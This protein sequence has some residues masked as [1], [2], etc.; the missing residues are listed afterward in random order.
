MKHLPSG[1]YPALLVQYFSDRLQELPLTIFLLKDDNIGQFLEMAPFLQIIPKI[2]TLRKQPSFIILSLQAILEFYEKRGKQ[3]VLPLVLPKGFDPTR[4][5]DLEWVLE[6]IRFHVTEESKELLHLLVSFLPVKKFLQKGL[7]ST[8]NLISE[9]LGDLSSKIIITESEELKK[10]FSEGIK[11]I[12]ASEEILKIVSDLFPSMLGFGSISLIL[13]SYAQSYDTLVNFII[14]PV[15]AEKFDNLSTGD[16]IRKLS[17]EYPEIVPCLKVLDPVLRNSIAHRNYYFDEITNEFIYY[18]KSINIGQEPQFYRA[19]LDDIRSRAIFAKLYSMEF[20]LGM[21]LYVYKWSIELLE[22]T[23]GLI[24]AFYPKVPDGL[25]GKLFG[26]TLTDLRELKSAVSEK[27]MVDAAIAELR[28]L[29][30]TNRTNLVVKG[31]EKKQPILK[32]IDTFWSGMRDQKIGIEKGKIVYSYI[33][34]MIPVKPDVNLLATLTRRYIKDF[35]KIEMKSIK[36]KKII[37]E[38]V[39]ILNSVLPERKKDFIDLFPE[40][41]SIN[42]VNQAWFGNYSE[43]IRKSV[44]RHFLEKIVDQEEKMTKKETN[45]VERMKNDP[46]FNAMLELVIIINSNPDKSL[47]GSKAAM[48]V[49]KRNINWPRP[50]FLKVKSCFLRAEGRGWLETS[51]NG[52]D[53]EGKITEKGTKIVEIYYDQQSK[54]QS[55]SDN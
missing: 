37:K 30:L 32:V 24:K 48:L 53:I 34:Y 10:I 49:R 36:A 15:G 23:F 11:E 21:M 47:T 25:I 35:L 17:E 5:E 38:T 41:E 4:Q 27:R 2:I 7:L 50:G 52:I 22:P 51:F 55:K 46:E 6:A 13:N 44:I 9:L 26:G 12:L 54:K 29:Y 8:Q 18:Q 42:I 20:L 45:I 1:E 19:N 33:L 14:R 43:N 28:M 39:I 40:I 31:K 16:V 3:D